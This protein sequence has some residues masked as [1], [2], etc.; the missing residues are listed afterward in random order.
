MLCDNPPH[1]CDVQTSSNAADSA[2]GH[3]TTYA[4]GQTGVPCSINPTGSNTSTMFAQEQVRHTATIGFR[5]DALTTMV[6]RGDKLIGSDGYTY[7]VEGINPGL[8]SGRRIPALLYV[9]GVS[10]W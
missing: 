6:K 1:T 7:H 9:T 10:L 3:A 8:A 4:A 5:T 2:G